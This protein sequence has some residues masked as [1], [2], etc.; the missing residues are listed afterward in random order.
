MKDIRIFVA[1][2]KEL[3][4]ERNALSYFVLAHEDEFAKRGLRVRLSKWEYV[5]PTMTQERTEDRYLDEMFNCD[6]VLMLFRHVLGMYTKEEVDKAIAAENAGT[7]RIKKHLILFKDGE[8]EERADL[9]EWRASLAEGTYGSFTDMEGLRRRFLCLVEEV[10]G[11][12]LQEVASAE[13]ERTVSAFIA[14]DDELV[15]DRNAFADAILNLNDVLAKRGVRVRM[16]F[17]DPDL[18]RELLESSDMAM[19]LYHTKCGAFKV[20]ALQESF[21]RSKREENPKRLYV[22]FR[23]AE[24]R[25]VESDFAALRDAFA[26][27][28]GS[29]PCK[30]ENVDTLS[31]NFLFSLESVLGDGSGQFVKLDGKTVVADGLEVGDLT[32]MPMLANNTGLSDLFSKMDD[33]S[34]RF[35]EQREK[36]E[37][38]PKDDGLYVTLLDLSSEKNRLQDQIDRELKMSLNLAKRLAAVSIAQVNETIARARA[39]MEAGDI[40][41]ALE[42]LDGASSAMKRRRLLH[43]AADRAEA[44]ELQIKE[45]KAGLEIEYFRIDAIMAYTEM[46]F[47]KRFKKVETIYQGVSD[48]LAKFASMCSRKNAVE[49]QLIFADVLVRFGKAYSQIAD[50]ITPIGLFEK[51]RDVYRSISGFGGEIPEKKLIS[52]CALLATRYEQNNRLD[53][54]TSSCEDILAIAKKHLADGDNGW[55]WRVA[56][57]SLAL[58]RL[59]LKRNEIDSAKSNAEFGLRY[60]RQLDAERPRKYQDDIADALNILSGIYKRIDDAASAKKCFSEEIEIARNLKASGHKNGRYLLAG[61]LYN[62]GKFLNEQHLDGEAEKI[63]C[64]SLALWREE[65]VDNPVQYVEYLCSTLNELAIVYNVLGRNKDSEMVLLESLEHDR[66]NA[67]RNPTR[68]KPDLIITSHNLATLYEKD[69]PEKA[70]EQYEYELKECRALFADEPGRYINMMLKILSVYGDFLESQGDTQVAKEK[71]T[72]ALAL[73][74]DRANIDPDNA[75]RYLLTPLNDLAWLHKR[76][77][78]FGLAKDKFE[79]LVQLRRIL[80]QKNPI[81]YEADLA[82]GLSLLGDMYERL[83]DFMNAEKCHAEALEIRRKSANGK[84][85]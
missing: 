11:M 6:A 9:A 39:K 58:A 47:E 43:K 79:E 28:F 44:E 60:L 14:V 77:K 29:E 56:D 1:S 4:P 55:G 76:Q 62:Y 59:H 48:D 38:N 16:R 33:L 8:V 24:G 52:V 75:G 50:S 17:Y 20:D 31:L 69:N 61:Y 41:G 42:I 51:A 37:Q 63:L 73:A 45:M 82:K 25:P 85:S 13:T 32:K 27:R 34:R 81:R 19:V 22:F 46:P 23:D 49:C 65:L 26:E 67:V 21:D 64:E 35:C 12:D 30:F 2:S 57:A 7:Q 72:E 66:R 3:L 68:F 40:K 10:S 53:V 15:V 78:E 70:R 80:A 5:D 83:G 36:C 74:R 18:H 54:A 84:E 71:Y